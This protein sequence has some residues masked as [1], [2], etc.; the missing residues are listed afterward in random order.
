MH[1]SRCEGG[2]VAL[3]PCIA[4][5]KIPTSIGRSSTQHGLHHHWGSSGVLPHLSH[6]GLRFWIHSLLQEHLVF[7]T[8][9]LWLHSIH[10]VIIHIG[11]MSLLDRFTDKGHYEFRVLVARSV[12]ILVAVSL[13]FL[14]KL[15]RKE[16]R[17]GWDDFW[18]LAACCLNYTAEGLSFWGMIRF[19]E[20]C[21]SK[22][23]T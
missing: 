11:N 3:R 5:P 10:S 19:H 12:I 18:I 6:A 14:C 9:R 13:R 8:Q 2:A 22:R 4:G 20:T 7:E 21:P 15:S 23:L 16:Q 1:G 17:F